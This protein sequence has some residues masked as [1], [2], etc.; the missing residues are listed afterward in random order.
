MEENNGD[1]RC[2]LLSAYARTVLRDPKEQINGF[3]TLIALSRKN[4]W[5]M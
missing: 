5:L 2:I 1:F 4:K 3:T